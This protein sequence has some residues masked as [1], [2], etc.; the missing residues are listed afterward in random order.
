MFPESQDFFFQQAA[1]HLSVPL[2]AF[3]RQLAP[4]AEPLCRDPEGWGPMSPTRYDFTPC[5]MD[6]WVAL[7][8]GFALVLGPAAVWYLRYKQE[9][10]PV[11]RNWHFYAK[12]VRIR[13][14]N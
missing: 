6:L 2:P 12:L 10:Q 5:F 3:L 14:M 1:P 8:A 9:P 11:A 7:V 4:A 13:S